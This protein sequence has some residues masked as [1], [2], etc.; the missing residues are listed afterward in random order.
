MV[1]R[2]LANVAAVSPKA[3]SV[4]PRHALPTGTFIP[5][6]ALSPGVRPFS[7]RS[8]ACRER[9]RELGREAVDDTAKDES[10]SS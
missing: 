1:F 6:S 7:F 4:P 5:Q 9:T 3:N 2:N 10:E 8:E